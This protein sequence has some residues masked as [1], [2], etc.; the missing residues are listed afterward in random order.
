MN[1]DLYVIDDR[2]AMNASLQSMEEDGIKA[3]REVVKKLK[4]DMASG[5]NSALH[6][7]KDAKGG[8]G[9][10]SGGFTD[11]KNDADTS[12][13]LVVS[14]LSEEDELKREAER[15]KKKE[16]YRKNP[17]NGVVVITCKVR[18]G[19]F[20]LT[21]IFDTPDGHLQLLLSVN[22][23]KFSI[24][25]STVD[26]APAVRK[27]LRDDPQGIHICIR[28]CIHIHLHSLLHLHIHSLLHIRR[29]MDIC[30]CIYLCISMHRYTCIYVL[31]SVNLPPL[32]A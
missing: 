26:I 30:I 19:N 5:G 17:L 2:E 22:N 20:N 27:A 14:M 8:S 10:G 31:T 28:I 6:S 16:K 12:T 25:D 7:P 11:K 24:Q 3:A 18:I 13:T 4:A 29:D 32:Q 15:K 1:E 9:S 23:N 21:D